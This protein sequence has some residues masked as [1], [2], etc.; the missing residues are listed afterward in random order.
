M[1]WGRSW[2]SARRRL[3]PLSSPSPAT[4]ALPT[5]ML[6]RSRWVGEWVGGWLGGWS[7]GQRHGTAG[8]RGEGGSQPGL[9]PRSHAPLLQNAAPMEQMQ[10]TIW[11]TEVL[12]HTE[13]MPESISLSKHL[14]AV[15]TPHADH[16]LGD[17]GAGEHAAGAPAGHHAPAGQAGRLQR[18]GRWVV[19][20]RG[21][22]RVLLE[23][24]IAWGGVLR[25]IVRYHNT[26]PN[27]P[28]TTRIAPCSCGCGHRVRRAPAL[29]SGGGGGGGHCAGALRDRGRGPAVQRGGEWLVQCGWV[30]RWVGCVGGGATAVGCPATRLPTCAAVTSSPHPLPTAAQ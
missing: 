9:L 16:D 19:G 5:C 26:P 17:G 18:A 7:W 24:G 30:G 4:P 12:V 28:N 25:C 3:A 15:S 11:E 6:R 13:T 14:P 1:R 29:H 21:R 20:V 23:A 22:G 8:I 10:T 27:T 2:R